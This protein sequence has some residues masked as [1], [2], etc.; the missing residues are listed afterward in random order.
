MLTKV[1]EEWRVE[2]T[3][4]LLNAYFDG[5]KQQS[6]GFMTRDNWKSTHKILSSLMVLIESV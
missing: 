2:V 1:P 5:A 4:H 6:S 3:L